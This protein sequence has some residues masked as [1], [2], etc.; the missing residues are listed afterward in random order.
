MTIEYRSIVW[1]YWLASAAL[2]AAGL[3]GRPGALT[4]FLALCVVQVAHIALRDRRLASFPLQT[5]IA[6]LLI[7]AAGL[8]PPLGAVHG[9][10][11]AGTLA[12]VVFGYCALARLLSLLPWNRREPLTARLVWKTFASPP[13]SGSILGP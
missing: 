10:L 11:L 12:R 1:W 4:A 6:Y 7:A 9:L 5:R 8:W 3:A 2:L 13:V